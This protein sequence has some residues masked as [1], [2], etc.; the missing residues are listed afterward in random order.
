LSDFNPARDTGPVRELVL[1]VAVADNEVIGN[2]GQLPWHLPADLARFKRLTMGHSM[3]M[4]RRTY[5]SI[6][7]LLP[8]R[9]TL[10]VTRQADYE[11]P[12]ALMVNSVEEAL[13]AVADDVRPFVTGGGEIYRQFLPWVTEV[14]LTRV[15]TCPP[16][17]TLMPDLGLADSGLW[18]L[19]E[20]ETHPA[21]EKNQFSYSFLTYRKKCQ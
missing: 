7:R 16:G 17:D 12:G 20:S 8:G 21:D 3:I 14:Q 18:D 6:G 9:T 1:I 2:A 4:G 15:H 5:D 11:V 10:I 19:V 13:K